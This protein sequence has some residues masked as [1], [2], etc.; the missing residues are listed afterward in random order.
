M[1][2]RRRE[3]IAGLGGVV[4]WPVVAT[5]Q[6]AQIPIVGVLSGGF[7]S[8]AARSLQIE[9]FRQG[10]G[11]MGFI[12]GR[13]VAL[14]Y[15]FAENHYDNL[16]ALAAELVRRQ[17]AVIATMQISPAALAAKAAT[18]LIPIVFVVGVDPVKLGIVKSLAR[19]GGNA[20]G[21]AFL[22][23]ELVPKRLELLHE[24]APAASTVAFLF[25][26]DSVANEVREVEDAAHR[27]GVR[28]IMVPAARSE[29][30]E[31][32]LAT[33]AVERVGALLIGGDQLFAINQG[34]IN[35]LAARHA[36]PVMWSLREPVLSGGLISY[37]SS[38]QEL[39]RQAGIYVG[40][41]LKGERPSDL[42]V[43]Q[44][45]KLELVVNLKTA[46]ALGLTVPQSILLRA[47]EVI[48]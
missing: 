20:T 26:P 11:E 25:N 3:F 46:K 24:L 8:T 17:V 34:R 39:A 2:M 15:R 31:R 30:I 48:E 47:D 12:E 40:R 27:L 32:A 1:L 38:R 10:L 14:D 36:L 44:A 6:Q 28:L 9:P 19:P 22:T 4:V 35:A 41:I 5:A 21:F 18:E 23:T 37:G 42:P 43:Q 16:P 29:E 7:D 45:T 33:L 13:N